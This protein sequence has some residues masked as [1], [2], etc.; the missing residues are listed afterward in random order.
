MTKINPILLDKIFK[1]SKYCSV[2]FFDHKN[3]KNV[4]SFFD[5][6][7]WKITKKFKIKS[8]GL[9]CQKNNQTKG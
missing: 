3:R 1:K 9:E 4:E 6:K 5:E 8:N 7:I 2:I